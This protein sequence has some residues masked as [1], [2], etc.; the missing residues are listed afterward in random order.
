MYFKSDKMPLSK[1][2]SNTPEFNSRDSSSRLTLV[3]K[4]RKRRQ[5]H[6][7]KSDQTKKRCCEYQGYGERFPNKKD[8]SEVMIKEIT[9]FSG[10]IVKR[11][12]FNPFEKCPKGALTW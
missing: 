7:L 1:K 5:C 2:Y 11:A 3:L 6:Y 12:S 8:Y 4:N 9:F 10:F